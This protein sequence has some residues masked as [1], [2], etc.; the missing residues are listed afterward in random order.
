[1]E[2]KESSKT[3]K[4]AGSTFYVD[5]AGLSWSIKKNNRDITFTRDGVE[6][7]FGFDGMYWFNMATES[8]TAI[9]SANNVTPTQSG[10][11]VLIPGLYGGVDVEIVS[12]VSGP[13]VDY[14]ITDMSGWTANPYGSDG[15][16]A[17]WHELKSRG[18][19]LKVDGVTWNGTDYTL[20]N[21][22]TF[23]GP[24]KD[25]DIIYS[26]AVDAND[27]TF[28]ITNAL[29]R[30]V[31]KDFFG[32]SIHS[33]WLSSASLPVRMHYDTKSTTTPGNETWSEGT[34][35]FI[36]SVLSTSG[37]YITIEKGVFV[38]FNDNGAIG[39]TDITGGVTVT[40]EW[41]DW[42]YFT[43][44]LDVDVARGEEISDADCDLGEPGVTA[45]APGDWN[46]IFANQ[47]SMNLVGMWVQYAGQSNAPMGYG[48]GN[49]NGD[50][51][52]V[53]YIKDSVFTSNLLGTNVPL[54]INNFSSD[55][56]DMDVYG[57]VFDCSDGG[58]AAMAA[59]I[60]QRDGNVS[61]RDN[62]FIVPAGHTTQGMQLYQ[63]NPTEVLRNTIVVAGGGTVGAGW[64]GIYDRSA[65]TDTAYDNVIQCSDG[66]SAGT[67][68]TG[69][70]THAYNLAY[71]CT[72]AFST[73]AGTGDIT[74]DPDFS[75]HEH[76]ELPAAADDFHLGVSSN[77]I[78]A[79]S[80]T[81]VNLGV[82]DA[83]ALDTGALDTGTVD[84]G[85]HYP[86]GGGGEE[87][88]RRFFIFSELTGD[89]LNGR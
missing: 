87:S 62:L 35:I 17:F 75:A 15:V 51:D 16:L 43:S 80:D 5:E 7:T 31:N 46:R 78:D 52:G 13:Q 23:T 58:V 37:Y 89:F 72:T 3:V 56:V 68:I 88:R 50:G 40:G 30:A 26:E 12:R 54:I 64:Q 73:G 53:Y 32:E 42:A 36:D 34:T 49:F 6:T 84:L 70:G 57:N 65:L 22:I 2:W 44:C 11:T 24:A 29:I 82:D 25:F 63:T 85:F 8:W 74:L 39:H 41:G 19:G 38:K 27:D 18:H 71:G 60:W 10:D 14:V 45:P 81:A 55:S 76:A 33:T 66:G 69:F 83:H 21:N 79:G 4:A 86:G 9:D 77:A 1:L 28:P 47:A 20:G 61:I 67:G 59:V 48:A